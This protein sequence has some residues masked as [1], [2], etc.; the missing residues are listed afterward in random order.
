MDL[1][2]IEFDTLDADAVDRLKRTED[3]LRFDGDHDPLLNLRSL[4]TDLNAVGIWPG[5]DVLV[6]P[7][8]GL[9]S[10]GLDLK[11]NITAFTYVSCFIDST[12]DLM[13]DEGWTWRSIAQS[14]T[15]RLNAEIQEAR[16]ALIA[17]VYS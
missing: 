16:E 15:D 6:T 17:P 4:I 1:H 14:V 11:V 13:P 3:N 10:D 7:E 12:D 8:G 5:R 9:V 2:T